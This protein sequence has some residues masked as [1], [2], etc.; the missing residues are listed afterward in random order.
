MLKFTHLGLWE[1]L[2]AP[3]SFVNLPLLL[4]KRFFFLPNGALYYEIPWH[5]YIYLL[6]IL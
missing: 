4:P 1:P 2:L 3:V 5:A 6:K